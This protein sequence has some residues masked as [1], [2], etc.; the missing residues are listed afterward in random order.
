MFRDLVT[1]N[2]MSLVIIVLGKERE[3]SHLGLMSSISV[4]PYR[5][6]VW[7]IMNM[8]EKVINLFLNLGGLDLLHV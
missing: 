3:S 7:S 2:G 8:S 1:L 4:Y 5:N 6:I